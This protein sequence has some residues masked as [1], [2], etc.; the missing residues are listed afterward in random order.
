MQGAH[1]GVSM[2]QSTTPRFRKFSVNE[3]IRS[4]NEVDEG[5]GSPFTVFL[6]DRNRGWTFLYILQLGHGIAVYFHISYCHS[7]L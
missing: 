1:P 7:I 3:L 4:M 5:L 6:S 2:G